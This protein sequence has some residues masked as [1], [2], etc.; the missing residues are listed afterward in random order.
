[1]LQS[2]DRSIQTTAK[3]SRSCNFGREVNTKSDQY[4][5]VLLYF[6][7]PHFLNKASFLQII[8]S[9]QI[10]YLVKIF[11][12]QLQVAT[13]MDPLV[14]YCPSFIITQPKKL[15]V[16]NELWAMAAVLAVC[17]NNLIKHF[18]KCPKYMWRPCYIHEYPSSKRRYYVY[19]LSMR[20]ILHLLLRSLPF[21][22]V[23]W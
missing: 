10:F 18:E 19:S 20:R 5:T 15:V 6:L 3:T 14:F 12:Y 1:M 7:L 13:R 11:M 8:G 9:I 21:Q 23:G 2:I 17:L 22:S 4:P 16:I